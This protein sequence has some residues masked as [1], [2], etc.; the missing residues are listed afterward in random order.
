MHKRHAYFA[1]L[2]LLFFALNSATAQQL[3]VKPATSTGSPAQRRARLVLFG[4]RPISPPPPG[5]RLLWL[6]PGYGVDYSMLPHSPRQ[7]SARHIEPTQVRPPSAAP[8]IFK[9]WQRRIE[10]ARPVPPPVAATSPADEEAPSAWSSFSLTKIAALAGALAL[11]AWKARRALPKVISIV[12]ARPPRP[13]AP[14]QVA[15]PDL[16]S[17][18][19]FVEAQR[20]THFVDEAEEVRGQRVFADNVAPAPSLELPQVNEVADALLEPPIDQPVLIPAETIAEAQPLTPVVEAADETN[21]ERLL[22]DDQASAPSLELPQAHEIA[23]APLEP[24]VDQPVLI[25]AET[26]A[27]AQPLTPV[28]EAADETNDE[29]LLDDDEASAP[30]LELP[31]VHE[32]ADAL[33]EPPIDQ[34]VL[35]SAETIAEAQ[36]LTPAAAAA[37]E[38]NDERLLDDD[39]APAPSLELPQVHEIASAPLEPTVDQPVLISAETIAEAQP[40]TPVA[41]AAD[42]TNDERLLDDD[43]APAPSLELPQAHEIADAPLEPTVDQP[44]L[45]S[46]EPIAEAQPLTPVVEAA[47]ETNDERLLDDDEAPAPSL[48]LPQA[49]GSPARLLS[50]LSINP[51]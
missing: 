20:A 2:A 25:P 14:K 40:L 23:S 1:L 45:I 47:D 26:I 42:E 11:L 44:V 41:E 27:E 4:L 10:P 51:F 5:E 38:T 18:E 33:L 50:R 32:V 17:L 43:E 31:Q 12:F 39:E 13:Q 49:H 46:A 24:T 22:D 30:S 6:R 37:D 34:P 21:D 28:A 15:E 29:R 36:P 16:T 7:E 3:A 48:E 9:L 8:Q 19:S 35:I